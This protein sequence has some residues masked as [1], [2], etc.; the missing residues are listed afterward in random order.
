MAGLRTNHLENL[1]PPKLLPVPCSAGNYMTDSGCQKCGKNTYSG[2]GAS[3]C[4]SC[5]NGKFSAE[6]S[7]SINDCGNFSDHTY[8]TI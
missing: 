6:G 1:N 8:F 4:I 5:P 2:D 7:S 3:S